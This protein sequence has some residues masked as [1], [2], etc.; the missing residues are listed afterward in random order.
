MHTYVLTKDAFFATKILVTAPANN[1]V[2]K[3]CLTS[4]LE[5]IFSFHPMTVF[6]VKQS[7]VHT[8]QN[9]TLFCKESDILFNHNFRILINN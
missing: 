3:G 2:V 5:Y 9:I 8:L 6:A 4:E 7:N 1:I